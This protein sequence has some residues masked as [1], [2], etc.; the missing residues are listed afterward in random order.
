MSKR[1]LIV[2]AG[3][4]GSLL[5]VYLARAGWTVEVRERRGDPRA[6][7]HIGGRSINLAIS[8]RGLKALRRVG[9]EEAILRDAIRM[10]GRMIHARDQSLNFQPYSRNPAHAIQSVSRSTL[11]L[12][13][14]RAAAAEAGVTIRFDQRCT[15]LDA[16]SGSATFHDDR[17]GET[18]TAQA[19][20]IVGT[21][22]AYSVLRGAMQ[23]QEGFDYQQS[24]LSHGFK[25]LHIPAV[26]S[27]ATAPF[28]MHPHAL[29]IWPRGGSMMIALPNP[30][31][32]FTCTIF[33]PHK[34]TASAAG[35]DSIATT[36]SARAHFTKHY[37]DA[38]AL[39]PTFDHDFVNNPVGWMMTVRSRPWSMGGRVA[40]LGDAAH[41][42]VP[43][44]GQGA[45]ASFED[46]E[47]LTD[48]LAA[49][50]NDIPAALADYERARKRNTDAIADMALENFIEMRDKTASRL[51]RWRKKAEHFI[52]GMAPSIFT[53]RYDM[54]SFDTIPYADAL[55]KSRRQDRV[56]TISIKFLLVVAVAVIYAIVALLWR[57]AL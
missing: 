14:I 43:F 5:A 24:W 26:T 23:K 18:S 19:D 48:A 20:L 21:D 13:L 7:G 45:N 49:S 57:G 38:L 53:P 41:A 47:A 16:T 30:D 46:C 31:G 33:W 39:M 52:H 8:A 50:H 27:G 55:A 9:L 25:E 1:V 44:F 6:A 2:G 3:L 51:F 34:T 42:I 22:G 56:I 15:D 29:H 10:P 12:T 54:V 11:N 17:T 35:F 37:Q 28:A 4:A 40:L 32:S 36:E